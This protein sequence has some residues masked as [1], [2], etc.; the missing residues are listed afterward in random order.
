MLP[1]WTFHSPHAWISLKICCGWHGKT[2]KCTAH[3]NEGE[4]LL[5]ACA[6]EKQQ[7][8]AMPY[9]LMCWTGFIYVLG[10]ERNAT[11]TDNVQQ[12][13]RH[14]HSCAHTPSPSNSKVERTTRICACS[15]S[16]CAWLWYKAQPNLNATVAMF[17]RVSIFYF[18]SSIRQTGFM[19]ATFVRSRPLVRLLARSLASLFV[20]S[21]ARS[22]AERVYN[23]FE[24]LVA[25]THASDTLTRWE[26]EYIDSD[27][28]RLC[29]EC[30]MVCGAASDW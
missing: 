13:D 27:Q 24:R 22:S 9:Q 29:F 25:Y 18:G 5:A 7:H 3:G 21:A 26:C 2:L 28:H 10:T 8:I 20:E 4:T 1:H 11:K 19:S 23:I 17:R 16:V 6:N 14:T 12:T 15:T 30:S